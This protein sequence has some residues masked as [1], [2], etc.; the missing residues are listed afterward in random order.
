MAKHRAALTTSIR[1]GEGAVI[2]VASR[3]TEGAVVEISLDLASAPVPTRSYCA[4]VGTTMLDD[5]DVLILCGQKKLVGG[6][7]RSLLVIRLTK[8]AA[9]Q[10]LGTCGTF[11]PDLRKYLE[12]QGLNPAPALELESEPDQT[13]A[14][15]ANIVAAAKSANEG[16]LD[17]YHVSP[18]MWADFTR[19]NLNQIAIDPVVRIMVPVQLLVTIL[20]GISAKAG[21]ES[22]GSR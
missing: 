3:R 16:C 19:H 20:D 7:L 6:G 8:Q 13:V 1:A 9:G 17:F 5:G 12:Q 18:R 4:D 21:T 11:H 2:D 10:F 22:E 14:L 15:V